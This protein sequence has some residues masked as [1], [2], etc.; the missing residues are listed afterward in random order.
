MVFVISPL[1]ENIVDPRSDDGKD[2]PVECEININIRVLSPALR[3]GLGDQKSHDHTD[4]DDQPVVCEG[5]PSDRKALH[6][7]RDRDPEVNEAYICSCHIV[8][9]LLYFFGE[10]Y[11]TPKTCK[12]Q[13]DSPDTPHVYS[14]KVD[15]SCGTF[16]L[17]FA[18]RN[19]L[20]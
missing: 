3:V 1:K 7:M 6:H 11:F 15:D 12:K 20:N 14:T 18:G 4:P 5:D 16:R 8:F 2:N 10:F 17:L 19:F 9:F 13:T